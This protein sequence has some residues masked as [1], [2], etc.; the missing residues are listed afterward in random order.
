MVVRLQGERAREARVR[1]GAEE[2]DGAWGKMG[3]V[4][5]GGTMRTSPELRVGKRSWFAPG[6]DLAVLYQLGRL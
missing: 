6:P 2:Q 3:V 5:E 1:C 4:Q